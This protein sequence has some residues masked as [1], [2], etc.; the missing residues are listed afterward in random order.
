M[1][2]KGSYKWGDGGKYEGQWKNGYM[3]GRGVFSYPD[4]IIYEGSYVDDMK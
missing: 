1:D 4:G 3:H 2:G